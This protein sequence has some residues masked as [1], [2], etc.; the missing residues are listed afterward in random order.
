MNKFRLKAQELLNRTQNLINTFEIRKGT[1][2]WPD[3]YVAS[4]EI[5]EQYPDLLLDTQMLLFSDSPNN[6][7]YIEAMKLNERKDLVISRY[8]DRFNHNDFIRLAKLL[9]KYIQHL[10]FLAIED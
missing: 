6:P 5:T 9:S 7:L 4:E 1:N 3:D 8:G 2:G 10:D